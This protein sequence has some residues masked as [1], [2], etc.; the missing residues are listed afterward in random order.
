MNFEEVSILMFIVLFIV[1]SGLLFAFYL[2]KQELVKANN[3]NNESLK[4]RLG[5]YE[6]LTLYTE[7]A[8]LKN[9]VARTESNNL[10]VVGLQLTLLETLKTEYEYNVSQQI[11]VSPELWSAIGNLKDQNIY[12]INQIAASLPSDAPAYTLNKALLEYSM[13]NNAELH[14]IVLNAL[15]FEAKKIL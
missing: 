4:L 1:M 15:Q 5:A 6:R 11:Y 12:I 9:L 3:K 10:N 14:S 13:N 7:R 2:I 8:S